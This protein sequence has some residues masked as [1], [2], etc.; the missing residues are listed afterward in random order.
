MCIAGKSSGGKAVIPSLSMSLIVSYDWEKYIKHMERFYEK[1]KE[2]PNMIYRVEHDKISTVQNV[3]LYDL[4]T[5]KLES[6]AFAKRPNNPVSTLKKGKGMFVQ[7]SI[8]EQVKCLMQILS[9]FGR[10]SGG[11]DLQTVGGAG[12]AAAMVGFS[13]SLGNWK[14]NYSNVCIIDQSA[15]G[16]FEKHSVNLLDLL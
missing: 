8:F 12:R 5:E 11:C 9:L 15:S 10:V 3:A 2:N 13:S 1:K 6:K 4:L 16:L 14:K 7:A